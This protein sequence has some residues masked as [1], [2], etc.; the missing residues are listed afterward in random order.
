[1]ERE[2]GLT[3]VTH[4]HVTIFRNDVSCNPLGNIYLV[5]FTHVAEQTSLILWRCPSEVDMKYSVILV[6]VFFSCAF[7]IDTVP[8][9]NVTKYLGRWY[10][11]KLCTVMVHD[12]FCLQFDDWRPFI[13]ERKLL[14]KDFQTK[15]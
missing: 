5:L 10:Q 7:G 4:C 9:L 2:A 14:E 3:T 11:V 1:M 6:A 8:S 12:Y 15:G 13:E